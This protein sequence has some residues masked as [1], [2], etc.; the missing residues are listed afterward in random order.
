MTESRSLPVAKPARRARPS[1]PSIEVGQPAALPTP[2]PA[3]TAAR[4]DFQIVRTRR[5]FEEV[6]AQVRDLLFQGSLKTGDRLPPER[7]LS[8][9][10]G[11]GRPALR[12]ALRALEASGLIELRKGKT[13]GAFIAVSSSR[14]VSDG[15]SDMLRLGNV[16]VEELFEAREWFLSALVRPVCRRITT[17]EIDRLR[18]NVA[19]AELLHDQGL[20]LDRIEQNFIFYTLLAQA[21]RNPVAVMVVDSLTVTLR[22]LIDRVGS[23]LSPHFFANRRDLIG[24]LES[25]DEEKAATLMARIVKATERTYKRL[26]ERT[27]AGQADSPLADDPPRARRSSADRAPHPPKKSTAKPGPKR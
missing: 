4:G 9:L 12:E 7:E 15:M 2:A 13:G 14:V 27:I 11:I 10:L 3:R 8:A 23:D 16:S 21:S 24:A 1:G 20:F 25:R 19:Q 18:K 17:E 26:L 5:T 22:A 6:T